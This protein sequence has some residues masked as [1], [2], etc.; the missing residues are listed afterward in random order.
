MLVAAVSDITLSWTKHWELT[1]GQSWN[2]L[3][4]WRAT[5]PP[6]PAA[7]PDPAVVA[8]TFPITSSQSHQPGSH[9]WNLLAIVLPAP[10]SDGDAFHRTFDQ[11]WSTSVLRTAASYTHIPTPQSLLTEPDL[12]ARSEALGVTA[13]LT[14]MNAHPSNNHPPQTADT[15][16]QLLHLVEQHLRD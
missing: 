7:H 16:H 11:W 1:H 14:L 4:S 5:Q 15:A 8:L 10:G 6:S 3:K 12:N 13:A 9:T 2:P